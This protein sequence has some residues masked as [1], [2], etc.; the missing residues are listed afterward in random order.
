MVW[1][2][3]AESY[4]LDWCQIELGL[5][6]RL[7]SHRELLVGVLP[8]QCRADFLKHF[9]HESLR[10]KFEATGANVFN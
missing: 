1:T 4:H 2:Q 10:V 5:D 7:Q 6:L 8:T 9:A 3:E